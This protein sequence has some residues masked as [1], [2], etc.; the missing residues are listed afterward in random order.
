M[1]PT[2][3]N[4]VILGG[5]LAGLA[6]AVYLAR[7]G[8][9]G[10][11]VVDPLPDLL[12]GARSLGTVEP[13]VLEHAHRTA[14]ALGDEGFTNLLT[15]LRRN[16]DLVAAEGLFEPC[17]VTWCALDDREPAALLEAAAT[18]RAHGETVTDLAGVDA[19]A[20][21]HAK[22]TAAMVLPAWG[23][24]EPSRAVHH[25][26]TEATTA[27]VTFL[28]GH[29]GLVDAIEPVVVTA[30]PHRIEAE[31]VVL[32]AGAGCSATSERLAASLTAVREA[33]L[34]L[35]GGH[36]PGIARA[37][38][39]WTLWTKRNDRTLVSGC[40]WATPHME[41]GEEDATVLEPRV[42]ARLEAFAR[43]K[44]GLDADVL[45]RWAWITADTRDHL[46]LIGPMPGQPRVLVA[47]GFGANS[48]SWSFAAARA[49]VDG[50]VDG[51]TTT[52]G[53]LRSNR[54]VRWAR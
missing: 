47:T 20:A 41:A 51:E 42:Q 24:L 25:L 18:L 37:G 46:P 33:A 5:G 16:R 39:G 48:A 21:L 32:A 19:A 40:R 11:V 10:L 13:G 50:L 45:E 49:V 1:Q 6:T 23:R 31:M 3:A 54:L 38:Q 28:L 15:F 9:D 26:L 22:V 2:T 4:V 35:P 52:P 29:A 53:M 8:I 36:D 17:G 12:Q 27:G 43:D 30:G 7:A 44:L 34:S 14:R